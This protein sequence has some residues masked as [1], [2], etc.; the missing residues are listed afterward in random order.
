MR[1]STSSFSRRN[2]DSERRIKDGHS[3]NCHSSKNLETLSSLLRTISTLYQ[4]SNLKETLT[5]VSKTNTKHV[6]FNLAM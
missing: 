1:N 6:G 5:A 4:A 3:R 2:T